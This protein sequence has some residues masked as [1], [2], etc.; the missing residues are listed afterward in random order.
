MRRNVGRKALFTGPQ[1]GNSLPRGALDGGRQIL[2]DHDIDMATG[3]DFTLFHFVAER[4]EFLDRELTF[5]KIRFQKAPERLG[6]DV[7]YDAFSQS[8]LADGV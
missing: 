1:P 7:G 8:L 4:V 2:D 5:L 3:E 6:P